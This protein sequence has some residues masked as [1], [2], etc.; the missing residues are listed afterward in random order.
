MNYKKNLNRRK[1]IAKRYIKNFLKTPKIKYMPY[2]PNSSFFVFQIFC[3]NRDEI[4]K[5]LKKEKIGVSVHYLNPL[6]K[7]T[8]YKKKYL[9]NINNFKNSNIYGKTNISLPVYPKLKN[10]EIDRICSIIKKTIK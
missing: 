8:Y 7:M 3:K 10:N 1:L 6:P 9:L 5:K 2:S 4:L